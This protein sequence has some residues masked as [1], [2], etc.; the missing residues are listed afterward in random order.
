MT[1]FLGLLCVASVGAIGWPMAGLIEGEGLIEKELDGQLGWTAS[2][3][4]EEVKAVSVT[5]A[6]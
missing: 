4:T 1:V 5:K 3:V 6:S 2:M